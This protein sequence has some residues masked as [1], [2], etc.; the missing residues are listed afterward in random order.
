MIGIIRVSIDG[1]VDSQVSLRV[2]EQI[3]RYLYDKWV[4]LNILW[5]DKWV[6]WYLY[7]GWVEVGYLYGWVDRR[8]VRYLYEQVGGQVIGYLYGWMGERVVEWMGER[9]IGYFHKQMGG[10]LDFFTDRWVGSQV[11]HYGRSGYLYKQVDIFVS[12][13]VIRCFVSFASM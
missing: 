10:Q 5:L 7:G 3:I 4:Q 9:V 13:Q 8:I 6:V 12:E 11:P 1:Q 2:G